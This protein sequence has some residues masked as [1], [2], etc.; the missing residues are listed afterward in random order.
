MTVSNPQFGAQGGKL[1]AGGQ[2]GRS[3]PRGNSKDRRARQTWM[4]SPE[5]GYGGNSTTVPCVHCG[6]AT[7]HPEADRIHPGGSYRRNNVQ[8]ACR[9][10]NLLRTNNPTWQGP[11]SIPVTGRKWGFAGYE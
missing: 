10:C 6:A 2:L 7:D 5:S 9:T 1:R 11:R 4:K 8:P 3:D